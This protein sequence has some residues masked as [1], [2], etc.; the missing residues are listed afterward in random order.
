M[1]TY[2]RNRKIYEK[3]KLGMSCAEIGREYG[4]TGSRVSQI[5]KNLEN[6]RA[7]DREPVMAALV[8]A[9]KDVGVNHGTAVRA[10][11]LLVRHGCTNE[12]KLA[13][14]DVMAVTTWRNGGAVI[15]NLIA[16]AQSM[17][18]DDVRTKGENW[19]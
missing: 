10:R 11:N 4:I 9:A 19:S 12:G 1:Q 2:E 18:R 6:E 13:E 7:R 5:V 17:V 14:L 16:A 15:K 8:N 3:R